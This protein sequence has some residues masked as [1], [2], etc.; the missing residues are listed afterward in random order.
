VFTT[1]LGRVLRS[2]RPRGAATAP[3]AGT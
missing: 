2:D 3:P 1:L